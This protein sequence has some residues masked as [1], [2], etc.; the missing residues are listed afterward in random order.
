M[1]EHPGDRRPSAQ[2]Q[3]IHCGDRLPQRVQGD[4]ETGLSFKLRWQAGARRPRGSGPWPKLASAATES[5][6]RTT[7]TPLMATL[8]PGP[9]VA[10]LGVVE[11]RSPRWTLLG[12]AAACQCRPPDRCRLPWARAGAAVR[13]AWSP[14]TRRYQLRMTSY[15]RHGEDPLGSQPAEPNVTGIRRFPTASGDRLRVNYQLRRHQAPSSSCLDL[16][17]ASRGSGVQ[18]PSAPPWSTAEVELWIGRLSSGPNA[19][20]RYCQ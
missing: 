7:P 20:E 3:G 18:I 1:P 13:T 12:R 10:H 15:S 17:F 8:N 5:A 6:R 19:S 16:W 14:A 9:E 2:K 4:V 11:A